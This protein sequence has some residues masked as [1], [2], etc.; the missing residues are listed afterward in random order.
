MVQCQGL[1]KD[2][3]H[4]SLKQR[5]ELMK[6]MFVDFGDFFVSFRAHQIMNS[7]FCQN[8]QESRTIN[9][10]LAIDEDSSLSL[11]NI[12]IYFLHQNCLAWLNSS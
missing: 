8:R 11:L 10:P 2:L 9:L 5:N 4:H 12:S 3:I 1:L 7:L 6:L